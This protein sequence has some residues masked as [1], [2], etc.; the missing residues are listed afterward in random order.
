MNFVA[1]T[2]V[3]QKRKNNEDS[4][5]VRIYDEKLSVFIVADGLGGY[6]SGEVAS[7]M[8]TDSLSN[9]FDKNTNMLKSLSQ[10]EVE[11]FLKDSLFNANA[12]IYEM[13][14]TDEKY[15]GMGTTV[16]C[17]AK[18]N[19]TIYYFSIGDSRIYYINNKFNEIEQITED[20]TYVNELVKTNIIDISEVDTHPK[21]HILTKAVGVFKD[22]DTNIKTFE[23]REGYLLLCTDGMTNMLEKVDILDI[24]K[25]NNFEKIA[26]KLVSKAND[27]GGNDNITVV[28]IKL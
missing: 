27:N 22:I 7:K 25:K 26:E 19:D 5:Y 6:E 9:D 23:E 3:G 20:D 21:K 11:Q 10:N 1:K 17:V 4:F 28:V 13:E 2:D 14:K 24:F 18:I 16:T 15:K 12:L 8:L